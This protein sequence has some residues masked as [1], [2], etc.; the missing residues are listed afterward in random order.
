MTHVRPFSDLLR[1]FAGPGIWFAHFV[2]LYGAEALICTPPIASSRAIVWAGLAATAVALTALGAFALMLW[3]ERVPDE[4]PHEH[5]G[6]AFL[7]G[8]PLL[9]A[10][11]SILAVIW[12]ALPIG[13]LA[14]CT[15]PAG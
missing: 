3:R 15:A 2:M 6:A 13:A 11:L 4:A 5:T 9:L 10:V 8:A 1:I 14:A 12:T 7:R